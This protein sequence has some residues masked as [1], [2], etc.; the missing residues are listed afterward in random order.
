MFKATSTFVKARNITMALTM[1]F[2]AATLVTACGSD[3]NSE[4]TQSP[5]AEMSSE[6]QNNMLQDNTQIA[7]NTEDTMGN[8]TV[9]EP[10]T[11]ADSE[12]TDTSASSDDASSAKAKETESEGTQT[13][14]VTAQGLIFE[15]LVIEINPGDTVAWRNMSTHNSESIDGLIPEGTEKWNSPMS[16]N[17]ERTFTQEGIY[18]YKCTPHFGAG[19]GGAIIVGK[20]VN[21]EQ[22]KNVDATGAAGRLVRKA[23]S[24]A[25]SM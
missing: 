18:V 20:P 17:Y 6:N 1:S 15:P 24:A 22:I 8:E 10:E 23:I 16:Q 9:V 13:H 12:E 4:T 2:A 25:E 3:E 5:E 19:M 21:L 11:S 7:S 14:V